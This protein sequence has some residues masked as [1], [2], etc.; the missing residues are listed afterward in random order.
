MRLMTTAVLAILLAL[1]PQVMAEKTDFATI[2]TME[3]WEVALTEAELAG[4]PIFMDMYTDWCG[5]C[6]VMD[7]ETFSDKKV[8]EYMNATFFPYKVDAETEVGS[9]L[10]ETYGVEGYPTFLIVDGNSNLISN[11]SGFLAAE[12]FLETLRSIMLGNAEMGALEEK[13]DTDQISDDE[14]MQLAVLYA[15]NDMDHQAEALATKVIAKSETPNLHKAV[16]GEFLGFFMHMIPMDDQRLVVSQMQSKDMGSQ[17]Q[18]MNMLSRNIYY[19]ADQSDRVRLDATLDLY[20]GPAC[21]PEDRKNVAS[22]SRMFFAESTGDWSLYATQALLLKDNNLTDVVELTQLTY[23]VLDNTDDEAALAIALDLSDYLMQE[24]P[25]WASNFIKA[26]ALSKHD[27]HEE[28][29]E[30]AQVAYDNCPDS[31]Q[32]E[33]ISSL[34]KTLAAN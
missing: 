8:G 20:V 34:Q 28:A 12:P 4:K 31:A 5:W 6:K 16:S 26:L 7:R 24:D 25:D 10:V 17:E 19:A 23:A 14:L 29:R 30:F 11:E 13:Y 9:Y 18:F 21:S 27:R 2:N 15:S 32:R 3:D 22:R 1:S 33:M